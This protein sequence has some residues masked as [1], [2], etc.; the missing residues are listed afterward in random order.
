MRRLR[1]G[2]EAPPTATARAGNKVALVTGSASGERVD[3]ST[4]QRVDASKR[5]RVQVYQCHN[6]GIPFAVGD[7]ELC[8]SFFV[9]F[10][11]GFGELL[12]RLVISFFCLGSDS[13]TGL[14]TQPA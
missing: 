3:L 11:I 13:V 8:S 5:R 7:F 4:R 2:A 1:D 12:F 6:V 14:D 9:L 10:R